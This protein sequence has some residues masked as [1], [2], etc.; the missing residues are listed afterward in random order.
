M[1]VR[2]SRCVNIYVRGMSY[3]LYEISLSFSAWNVS[4]A[5]PPSRAFTFRR[6]VSNKLIYIYIY[7]YVYVYIYIYT[8]TRNHF[9]QKWTGNVRVYTIAIRRDSPNRS[10]DFSV[11]LEFRFLGVLFVHLDYYLIC[12]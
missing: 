12:S 6:N 1:C 9:A 4:I 10:P 7:M 5:F 3:I 8:R 11:L 2:V